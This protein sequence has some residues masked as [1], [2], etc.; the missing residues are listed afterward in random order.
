M[1]GRRRAVEWS[2]QVCRG[3]V[4]A[5]TLAITT[6]TDLLVLGRIDWARDTGL[7]F[8][9]LTARIAAAANCSVMVLSETPPADQ[10][11]IL[12]LYEEAGSGDRALA[13]AAILARDTRQPLTILLP[14]S[15]EDQVA[16]L[17]ANAR[18]WA[19]GHNLEVSFLP[20]PGSDV[21]TLIQALQ[22]IGGQM[23]ILSRASRAMQDPTSRLL[24]GQIVAP[25][26]VVP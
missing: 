14:P 5:E 6:P 9:Q 2:L 20:L 8:G 22:Q 3:R 23:L 21:A 24:L 4:E 16:R 1:A 11:S 10:Q 7:R 26:V 12:V 15:A 18:R 17:E 19:Q 13:T 25:V